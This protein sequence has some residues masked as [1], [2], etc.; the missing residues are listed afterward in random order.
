MALV[1]LPK[2]VLPTQVT[3]DAEPDPPLEAMEIPK[4]YVPQPLAPE[5]PQ[6]L[7]VVSE[8]P[9]ATKEIGRAS[10]REEC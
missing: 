7:E 10:C 9:A 6:S 3:I 1:S 5:T 8:N 2:I 4:D